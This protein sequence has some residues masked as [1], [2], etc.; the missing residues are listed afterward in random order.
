MDSLPYFA[1][2]IFQIVWLDLLLSGD[3]AVVIALACRN[4]PEDKRK[5]G[6]AIGAGLAVALR[7]IFTVLVVY[8]LK[9]PYLKLIGG[10]LLLYIAVKLVFDGHDHG[11]VEAKPNVW[12]AV[13]TIVIADGVMSLDNVLAIVG[14]AEEHLGLIIFG[15]VLSIPLVVFGA[16][17]VLKMID[18][19]P[20]IVWAG[21]ALL[22]WVAGAMIAGDSHVAEWLAR[23]LNPPDKAAGVAGMLVVLAIAGAI[24]FS[25]KKPA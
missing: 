14:V 17:A 11:E 20:I 23:N 4:L 19:W 25:R 3:N 13:T 21:A 15:L 6:I 22:G 9:L 1:F 5:L 16:S 7:L 18:R 8:L 2:Q 12:G 24:K 10:V